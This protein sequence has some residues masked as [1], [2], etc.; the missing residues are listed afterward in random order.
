MWKALHTGKDPGP[1]AGPEIHP[2]SLSPQPRP[3]PSVPLSETNYTAPQTLQTN[4]SSS[5]AA[6]GRCVPRTPLRCLL[7]QTPESGAV[8]GHR[9]G[10]SSE[11]EGGRLSNPPRPHPPLPFSHLTPQPQ[12]HG[13]LQGPG[14]GKTVKRG[15]LSSILTVLLTTV[16]GQGS[17]HPNPWLRREL[18][19]P[20]SSHG[21]HCPP[22]LAPLLPRAPTSPGVP[23]TQGS[24][25]SSSVAGLHLFSL[26]LPLPPSPLPLPIPPPPPPREQDWRIYDVSFP[27][28]H[29]E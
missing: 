1:E 22:P 18:P 20:P 4:S 23:P 16:V 25:R 2:L 17:N 11:K 15:S 26:P 24:G 27:L 28:T 13:G 14:R 21:S 19:A 7:S 10:T 29:P 12:P 6:E 3:A 9:A 5:T 8:V